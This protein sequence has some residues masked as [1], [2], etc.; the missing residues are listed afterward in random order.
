ME[1]TEGHAEI[2]RS[3]ERED[4]GD[5]EEKELGEGA[6]VVDALVDGVSLEEILE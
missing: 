2:E 1:V 5:F 6:G 4:W 3:L